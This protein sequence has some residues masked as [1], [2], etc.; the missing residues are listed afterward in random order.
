MK[1]SVGY[2]ELLD[3]I[4][5]KTGQKIGLCYVSQDTVRLTKDIKLPLIGTKPIGLNV[6]VLGFEGQDLKLKTVSGLISKL[7][8]LVSWPDKDKYIVITNDCITVHLNAV[9]QMDKVF[10]YADLK[11]LSFTP[12]TVELEIG[13]KI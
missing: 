2:Q 13:I 11:G 6:T 10:E 12:E 3:I 8:G 5:A 7:L 4:S 1:I 9:H